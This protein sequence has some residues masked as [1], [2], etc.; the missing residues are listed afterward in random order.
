M[1]MKLLLYFFQIAVSPDRLTP[2]HNM[3]DIGSTM[4]GQRGVDDNKTV[5]IF[6]QLQL[7][8]DCVFFESHS[9]NWRED[10]G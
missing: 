9:K 3:R 8:V 10:G 5:R 4:N 6:S 2:R 7:S 1:V